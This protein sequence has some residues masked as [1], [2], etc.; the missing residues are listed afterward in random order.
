MFAPRRG[1]GWAPGVGVFVRWLALHTLQQQQQA[2]RAPL[3]DSITPAVK[4][5]SGTEGS[6]GELDPS[7]SRCPTVSTSGS[8][9]RRRNM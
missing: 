3:D 7:S 6:M 4:N 1:H 8:H 5:I 2:Y 9:Q